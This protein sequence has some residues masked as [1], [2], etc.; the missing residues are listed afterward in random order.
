VFRQLVADATD[1]LVDAGVSATFAS[2]AGSRRAPGPTWISVTSPWGYGRLVRHADGSFDGQA[3]GVRD[4]TPLWAG[5]GEHVGREHLELLVAAV[6]RPDDARADDDG[7]RRGASSRPGS[8]L[9]S[10]LGA[11]GAGTKFGPALSSRQGR[12]PTR[13]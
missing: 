3:H 11:P 10:D 8:P 9:G 1:V 13:D 2:T 6:S 7:P 5:H 12:T 4:G